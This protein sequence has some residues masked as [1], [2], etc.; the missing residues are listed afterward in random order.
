MYLYIAFRYW[1]LMFLTFCST[2]A[3]GQTQIDS[4]VCLKFPG[5]VKT[6]KIEKAPAYLTG[7]YLNTDKESYIIF[8][9]TLIQN[10]EVATDLATD[11]GQLTN[12][13]R[14]DITNQI[15][16]MRRKG[17]VFK[18]STRINIEGYVAYKVRY[19]G[20]ISDS[21]GAE[22]ILLFLNGARY[23]ITYSRV[24]TYNKKNSDVFFNSLYIAHS[25]AIKQI[26]DVN[27][28]S[29]ILNYIVIGITAIIV[30]VFFVR[31]SKNKSKLG[32]NLKR[33][34]CPVCNTRQPVLR[35][36]KNINQALV[37]GTTCVKC[38]TQLD[39]Y[40]RIIS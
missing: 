17:F 25:N 15:V 33:V 5:K 23:I 26:A 39:K 29:P 38:H 2:I 13:Y 22:S 21:I 37:G 10:G 32:I 40:G 30:V 35:L 34:Y 9:T 19:V 31:A 20:P 4:T 3:L 6:Y 16:P 24:S 11:M 18:D 14:H 1:F 36:P 7:L 12:I 27:D 8:K 28:E